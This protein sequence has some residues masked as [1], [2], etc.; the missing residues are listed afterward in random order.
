MQ[1]LRALRLI[2]SSIV[3]NIP[4]RKVFGSLFCHPPYFK[5]QQMTNDTYN[6]CFI[7]IFILVGV[8]VCLECQKSS[9]QI[10]QTETN[11]E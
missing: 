8:K 9:T 4:C 11:G 5:I 6:V 10:L 7:Y 1:N 2:V 3:I